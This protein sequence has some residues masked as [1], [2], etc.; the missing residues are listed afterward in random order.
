MSTSKGSDGTTNIWEERWQQGRTGW[1]QSSSH[2]FLTQFLASARSDELGV[3]RTGRALVPGCGTGY[4]V[5]LFAQWGLDATG[6]DLAPTGVELAKKWLESQPPTKG[7]SDIVVA[8]F[9]EY[10]PKDKFD[11]I[12]DYTFLCALPPDLRPAWSKQLANLSKS[13]SSTTLIT[14]M[15]PLPPHSQPTGPPWPLTEEVYHELLDEQWEL[16][17][18]EDVPSSMKRTVGAQGGEKL[19]VWKRRV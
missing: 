19:G 17:W 2:P 13:A 15:Y 10:D 3:P 1:D 8:D 4:D 5:N 7:K 9:F 16:V 11:L 18:A 14:L 6:I 12:F